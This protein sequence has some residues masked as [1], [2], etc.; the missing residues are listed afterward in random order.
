MTLRLLLSYY[1]H[2]NT[3]IT[4]IITAYRGRC[5]V[6]A[7][8][9]AYSAHTVGARIDLADYAGWLRNW[10][11]LITTASTLDVIGD[12][13]ATER[14]TSRLEGMGLRV[15]PVFHTGGPWERLEQLCVQYPYV[16]LGGMVPYRFRVPEVMRWL[17]RCFQIGREC[18]TRF[19]GFGLTRV[20][21][22]RRLPFYSVDS[23]TCAAGSRYGRL[24]FW[25]RVRS[26]LVTVHAGVPAEAHRH[27]QLITAHG[28]NP[29]SVGRPGFAVS[30]QRAPAQYAVEQ[31]QMLRIPALA[32]TRMGEWLASVHKVPAPS[33]WTAT[34][35]VLYLAEGDPRR[36]I[37]L[38]RSITND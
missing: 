15:L 2:R 18:G 7:D 5:E 8:S 13:A 38:A 1:S 23:S 3:D 19:H 26:N 32:L 9:G 34:G 29:D 4:K 31:Q 30:S 24:V 6:F 11:G 36:V 16:A 25:D 10:Q 17:I 37:A 12:P 20:E 14:N 22:L 27:A 33:G 28:L 21:M 35:T